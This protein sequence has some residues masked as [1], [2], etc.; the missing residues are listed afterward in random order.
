MYRDTRLD[1][2]YRLDLLVNDAVI[3][4]IK[5]VQQI[6]DVHRAQL[7]SY[8]KL[9]GHTVGV[10]INFNV[11]RLKDGIERVVHRA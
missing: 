11:T 5:A 8:L 4:E 10:L 7:L 6:R 2:G 1:V 9:S 3:V